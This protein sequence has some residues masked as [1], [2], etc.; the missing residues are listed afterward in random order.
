M[1]IGA[2]I[3]IEV[4]KSGIP[5]LSFAGCFRRDFQRLQLSRPEVRN[6]ISDRHQPVSPDAEQMALAVALLA[7]EAGAAQHAEVVRSDLLGHAEFRRDFPYRARLIPDQGQDAAPVAVGQGM[8]GDLYAAA[9][10]SRH[11][12]HS[13]GYLYKCQWVGAGFR[14]SVNRRLRIRASPRIC[15]SAGG[16]GP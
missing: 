10:G 14:P 15:A 1:S 12:H 8:P 4:A 9:K 2:S 13:S 5:L 16:Q 3:S 11:L 7:D 6:K